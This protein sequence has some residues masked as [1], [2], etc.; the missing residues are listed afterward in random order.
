MNNAAQKGVIASKLHPYMDSNVLGGR[1]LQANQLAEEIL[2]I[3]AA[4]NQDG[5]QPIKSAPKDGTEILV[6]RPL[7]HESGDPIIAIKRTTEK[8]MHCWKQTIPEGADGENYTDG[9]CY[10]THWQPLPTPPEQSAPCGV[11]H[12]GE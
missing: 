6:Y 2:A 7:A 4:H 5:W 3:V 9:A 8:P 10:A 1:W 11:E 12:G